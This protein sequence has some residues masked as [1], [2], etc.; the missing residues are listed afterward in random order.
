MSTVTKQH[1]DLSDFDRAGRAVVTA[2]FAIKQTVR[3]GALSSR[4]GRK[5]MHVLMGPLF[6]LA[7]ER[8]PAANPLSRYC[9]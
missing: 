6:L 4:Q 1:G 2:D 7:C 3:H 8:F 9:P 5:L